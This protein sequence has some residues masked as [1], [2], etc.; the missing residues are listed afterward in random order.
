MTNEENAA[1][2]KPKSIL[3]FKILATVFLIPAVVGAI[4]A[5]DAYTLCLLGRENAE[6]GMALVLILCV[7]L[8]YLPCNLVC[9]LF[10]ILGLIKVNRYYKKA[11]SVAG[12]KAELAWLIPLLC[13]AVITC[14]F[15]LYLTILYA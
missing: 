12:K 1:L 13:V 7:F 8:W 15:A 2:K 9:L 6:L 3:V 4:V 11:E 5:A 10:C 14:A